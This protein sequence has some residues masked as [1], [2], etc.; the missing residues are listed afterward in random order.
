MFPSQTAGVGKALSRVLTLVD[1][2]RGMFIT[3]FE[4]RVSL[5]F[6]HHVYFFLHLPRVCVCVCAYPLFGTCTGRIV[7]AARTNPQ[8]T[9]ACSSQVLYW[10][11]W[12]FPPH[13]MVRCWAVRLRQNRLWAGMHFP[14]ERAIERWVSLWSMPKPHQSCGTSRSRMRELGTLSHGLYLG[15]E[16]KLPYKGERVCKDAVFYNISWSR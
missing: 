5:N 4:K 14:D 6:V 15:W 11:R 16:F 3:A 13:A 2:N 9:V 10:F 7:A 1:A 12:V 8:N